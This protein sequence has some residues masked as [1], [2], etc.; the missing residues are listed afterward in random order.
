M[1]RPSQ[2]RRLI[3]MSVG[4]LLSL[5]VN[6][7]LPSE[8]FAQEDA[9]GVR[10]FTEPGTWRVPAGVTHIIVELWGAG[11]GGG[12]GTSAVVS[13][14]PGAGG[15][16]GGGGS[17]SYMRASLAVTAGETY[18]ISVGAAGTGGRGDAA[19]PQRG[20]DGGDTLLLRDGVELLV[21]KGGRGGGAPRRSHTRG[22]AEGAGGITEPRSSRLVRS[23][24]A[25][26]RGH[27]GGLPESYSTSGG[28]GGTAVLG[29]VNPPG[30]FGGAGGAGVDEGPADGKPGGTGSVL[31]TW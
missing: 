11:G 16:G 28:A 4:A 3:G 19:G 22:G 15:G 10:E 1:S 18:T 25:G 29:T 5:S 24:S 17:G 27:D 12:A 13:G 14:V 21:A 23:G 7:F 9:H 30:S 26:G 8:S 2:S 31:I 20:G 6:G